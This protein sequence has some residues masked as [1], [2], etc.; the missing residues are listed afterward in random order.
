MADNGTADSATK[1]ELIPGD[2]ADLVVNE[3]PPLPPSELYDSYDDLYNFLQA[4]ARSNGVY[5][6]KKSSS[7]PREINGTIIATRRLLLCDRG[8]GRPSRSRGL[9]R[10]PSQKEGCPI[11]I[12]AS[13][14]K[15][16]NWRWSYRVSGAHN[17]PPS[18]HLSQH[19]VHR[20]RTAE[21]Q[22]LA[23]GLSQ[24]RALPARE[25]AVA[26]RERSG[27]SAFFR[28]RDIWNDLQQNRS[29]A[30]QQDSTT[31][32]HSGQS[33]DAIA[34]ADSASSSSAAE[35]EDVPGHTTDTEVNASNDS[36]EV[37][38]VP[39]LPPSVLYDSFDDL[40][41]F[42][43]AWARFNGVA[44]VK[45]TAS[46]F[47]EIDGTRIATRRLLLCDRGPARPSTSR[48]LRQTPTQRAGCPIRITASVTM[49]NNLRWSYKVSGAHNHPPSQHPS[50]HA[51]HR[52]RTV[53][54]RTL[55]SE[56][57]QQRA[58]P[59]REVAIAL[60]ERSGE[61]AF[62]RER[63]IHND[64]QR[65]RSLASP[66]NPT[67]V[68]PNGQSTY[69]IATADPASPSSA[70]KDKDVSGHTADTE[71]SEV[72]ED[73]EVQEIPPLPP[74]VLYDSFDDLFNFVQAWARSNG[75]AF[76]KRSASNMCEIN[77]TKLSTHRLLL[78]DRG[79]VRPST[80]RD[81]RCRKPTRK[82]DC[83][84][85]IITSATPKN[86]WRWSYRVSGAHNH[87]RSHDPSDNSMHRRRTADQRSLASK[88]TR[89]PTLPAREVAVA[90]RERSG[91]PASFRERGIYNDLQRVRSFASPQDSTTTAHNE[92]PSDAIATADPAS[93]SSA[94]ENESS[95]DHSA[96]F[97]SKEAPSSSAVE[98]EDVLD[99]TADT[100]VKASN[101]GNEVQEVPPLP[102]S[103]L[104]DSFDDLF[105]FLQGWARSNGVAF[106]KKSA[107]NLREING[108]KIAAHRLLLCDRGPGR[109]SRSRGLRRIPSQKAD[110]P[111]RI[112]ASVTMKNNWRWSY[113][114]SGAHNH[115][116]SHHPS[117][118]AVHRRRTAEQRVLA[119][120]LSQQRALPAREVAI[121]LRERSGES[122]FFRESDIYNDLKRNRPLASPRNSTTAAHNEQPSDSI[123]T[124]DPASPSSA[125]E[126]EG[127]LGHSADL[128]SKE[129]PSSSAVEGE[130]V[131]DHTADT[132]VNA[133]NDGNEVQEVPPLPPSVLYDSFDDLYNFLQGWARS[134]G[135][136]F[137]KK[138]ASN[139]REINGTIIATHRLLLCDRGSGRPSTGRGLR[140]IP[141]QKEDCPIR[142]T[143]SVTMK[144]NLRW[145]YRVSGAHNHPPSQHPSQ[146][147]VHRRR[148][149]E[150][151]VLALELSQ[152][153]ALPARE[154][155]IA[156]RERSGEPA[157]F[158]ERDIYNDLQ[159][160]RS[161]ASP[162][163]PTTVAPNGQSTDAI[164]TADP[165]SPSS[166][167]KDKDVPGHTADTEDNEVQEIPPLP[168]SE[169]YD[170]FDDLFNFL[171]VWARSN[172]VFFVKKSSSN[173]REI[174]GTKTATR[175]LVLCDRGPG[176]SSTSLDPR[177]RKPTRKIDCPFR[178]FTS[179]TPKNNWR[180]SYRVSGAH[181]H[182]PDHDPSENYMRRRR[183]AGQRSLASKPTQRPTLPVRE[184]AVAPKKRS[185]I[186]AF[187]RHRDV[188]NGRHRL[189]RSRNSKA[190]KDI[191]PDHLRVVA[192]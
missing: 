140:R 182:P 13:V 158:R 27:E 159:R 28:E 18:H 189:P 118:H 101:E 12:T 52:R 86:N 133:S 191:L 68:A 105:N 22:V 24:Q 76:V 95:L 21:Q 58:L 32:A 62:F 54:Q 99:H 45:K 61:P 137:V 67:T 136:A 139:P 34:T 174:N 169:L 23:L 149:A 183:T 53:D 152:Q 36:N 112:T 6:V 127:P 90:L 30:S 185:V 132:E 170:T 172:G 41:N 111:I 26:L 171:Q 114:V 120:E 74:S 138:S 9:R 46:N 115:P 91:E 3:V 106:V 162:R 8:P 72:D 33:P 108:T 57:S 148:T 179:A 2:T 110:C 151:R 135:V 92:Q 134:N 146:H 161:L 100:E 59:A 60:R 93:P 166:A 78:C 122:A 35:D 175:R 89:R 63:D 80:S 173:P 5:F 124:A 10:I 38:E 163:N 125:A 70:T 103:E 56:L 19:A 83:P 81:L 79:P 49:K 37:Q 188:Y 121:A 145:S 94:A 168:P 141:S 192:R 66:R 187:F 104:Y 48:D 144:N 7:H 69:A 153:R 156:L 44:F 109:P 150:Q 55:A 75:V 119:L 88:P 71:V 14:T 116:P 17:H 20:R 155:A 131:L 165:A 29:L 181:N 51:V 11:R 87:P 96:D 123:A 65:N 128:E 130:D 142:I 180:W 113:R 98:G 25:V 154:V 117:Q 107:S 176:Q 97:E 64:L 39:P 43:Q 167:T 190:Q 160:N 40:Y 143:A 178:I 73:N 31:A 157:F 77:G 47:R 16:N 147:A 84:F 1:N 126:N 184:L 102:P 85:R 15:R 177:F 164:A 4:W 82:I 186:P 42:V 129:A 50:Q